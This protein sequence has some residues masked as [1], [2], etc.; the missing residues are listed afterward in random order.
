MGRSVPIKLIVHA[1]ETREGRDALARR[2][3]QIQAGFVCQA[4]DH[5]PCADSRKP[6]LLR[7]VTAALAQPPHL[8]GQPLPSAKSGDSL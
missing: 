3:A 2:V 7:Q 1:P 8:P 5:L 4:V 6:T